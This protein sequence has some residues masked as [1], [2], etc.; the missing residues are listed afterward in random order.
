MAKKSFSFSC[1]RYFTFNFFVEK[2][3]SL[4]LFIYLN[5]KYDNKHEKFILIFYSRLRATKPNKS[6]ESKRELANK[7]FQILLRIKS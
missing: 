3:I 5:S 1:S 6:S 2:K 7:K 4:S